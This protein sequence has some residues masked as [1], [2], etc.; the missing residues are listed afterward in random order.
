MRRQCIITGTTHALH[1]GSSSPCN[2]LCPCVTQSFAQREAV[3]IF[4]PP[5]STT[6]YC[7]A[8]RFGFF[9]PSEREKQP[10]CG[11]QPLCARSQI[12]RL[13]RWPAY[14]II[15]NV[16]LVAMTARHAQKNKRHTARR[17]TQTTSSW[18][19]GF[20]LSSQAHCRC[21]SRMENRNGNIGRTA[22]HT[23]CSIPYRLCHPRM[24]FSRRCCL[25]ESVHPWVFSAHTWLAPALTM[26][27]FEHARRVAASQIAQPEE[28]P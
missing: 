3:Q 9:T 22:L 18:L 7:A 28:R 14:F 19:H 20:A 26:W 10:F 12:S 17:R 27:C 21:A 11:E 2:W 15:R 4:P 24:L 6:T 8:L 5:K 1:R 25:L 23:F 13:S 16:R